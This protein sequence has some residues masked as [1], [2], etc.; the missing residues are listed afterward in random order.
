LLLDTGAP[1]S[2][3]EKLAG[4]PGV[5]S[6]VALDVA[7]FTAQKLSSAMGHHVDG[8]IGADTLRTQTIHIN[9]A[10]QTVTFSDEK[11]EP[12]QG[13]RILD[14]MN[15]PVVDVQFNGQTIPTIFDTGAPLGYVPKAMTEGRDP[16]GTF[17]DFY[18]LCGTFQT[19]IFEISVNIGEWTDIIPFGVLPEAIEQIHI[20]Q[21][22]PTIIGLGLLKSF[23]ISLG[24]REGLMKLVPL[25]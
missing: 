2:F 11:I 22:F 4:I 23:S 12:D 20:Q 14:K 15:V 7:G 19:D 25:E 17:D 3:G 9:P 21:G 24:H 16:V 13:I 1:F 8:V 6:A 5:T 18:P 10:S